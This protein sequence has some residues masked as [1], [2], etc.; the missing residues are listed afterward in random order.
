MSRL[1]W[2]LLRFSLCAWIGAAALFVVTGVREVTSDLFDPATKNQLAA[3]RF[4]AFY[5]FG[6]GLVGAATVASGVLSLKSDGGRKRMLTVLALVIAVFAAM[7]VDYFW[8]YSPL[9]EMM[10]QPDA[11]SRPEFASYHGMSKRI[12]IAALSVC[13]VAA[14]ISLG[15]GSRKSDDGGGPA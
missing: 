8:I 11:R 5:L 10:S 15:D 12:N 4:P 3:L 2:I 1:L 6:F 14:L 9:E 13:F 7:V